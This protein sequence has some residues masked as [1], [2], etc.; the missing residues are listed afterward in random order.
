MCVC[1]CVCVH[2]YKFSPSIAIGTLLVDLPFPAT[3]SSQEPT[4][5][6]FLC[7]Y[8]SW[9]W[10][11]SLI[12]DMKYIYVC[13]YIYTHI[14]R[15]Q[16][17]SVAQSCPTLQLHELQHAWVGDAIQPSHPLS[18]PSPALNLSQ[19]QSLFQWVSSSHQVAKM[20]EFQLQHQSFQWT[21]RTDLL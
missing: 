5:K 19:H 13:V 12:I 2:V 16:F 3:N 11:A 10:W 9:M 20:L 14:H 18:A 7:A 1:V 6:H 21:P 17:S 4:I 15:N 8:R